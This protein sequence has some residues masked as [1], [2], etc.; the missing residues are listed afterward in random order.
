MEYFRADYLKIH[1][2]KE[3]QCVWMEWKK[4][5]KGNSFRGGLDKGL[6]LIIE[7]GSFRWLADLRLL[8]VVDMDDQEWSNMDWFP[9]AINGGIRYMAI[10]VPKNIFAKMS[11]NAIMEKVASRDLTVHYFE[12]IEEAE[13]WL[14]K[15]V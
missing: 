13:D 2:N 11:V 10:L 15:Q 4:F 8:K 6:K 3:I 1:W 12:S 5:V 7:K 9:R 14:N